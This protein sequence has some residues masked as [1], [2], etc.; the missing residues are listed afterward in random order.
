LDRV[1]AFF[2]ETEV[3][4][5]DACEGNAFA[6]FGSFHEISVP[7]AIDFNGFLA[8]LPSNFT[9]SSAFEC[10]DVPVSGKVSGS[11]IGERQ[12]SVSTCGKSQ[13]QP[14][15]EPTYCTACLVKCVFIASCL[16]L[17]VLTERAGASSRHGRNGNGD[18]VPT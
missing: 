16:A 10:S 14:E 9:N 3:G 8:A 15:V 2:F 11:N 1:K 13:P 12:V 7:H 4:N 5:E 6:N 18:A 17:S